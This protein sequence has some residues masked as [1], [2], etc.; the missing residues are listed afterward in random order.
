MSLI[1]SLVSVTIISGINV[2]LEALRI[3]VREGRDLASAAVTERLASGA[4]V[5]ELCGGGPS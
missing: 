5:E 3:L 1:I 4:L 2:V